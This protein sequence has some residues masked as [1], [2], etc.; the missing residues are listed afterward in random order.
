MAVDE[1]TSLCNA[2][3][4]INRSWPHPKTSYQTISEH[5]VNHSDESISDE[6]HAH[7][8]RV[9]SPEVSVQ[10]STSFTTVVYVLLLGQNSLLFYRSY[11]NI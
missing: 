11:S 9:A 1:S 3:G 6:E 10:L 5:N 4:E 8:S 7:D 2:E